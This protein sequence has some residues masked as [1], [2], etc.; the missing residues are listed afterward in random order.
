FRDLTS[1]STPDLINLGPGVLALNTDGDIVYVP[2]ATGGTLGALCTDAPLGN[3]TADNRVGLNDFAV[4]FEDGSIP[5]APDINQVSVGFDCTELPPAKFS[6]DNIGQDIGLHTETSGITVGFLGEAIAI[7]ALATDNTGGTSIGVKT[8]VQGSN[9][10]NVGVISEAFSNTTATATSNFGGRFLATDGTGLNF[11]LFGGA[12]TI[13]SPPA[14]LNVGLGGFANNGNRNTGVS[15]FASGGAIWNHGVQGCA[16]GPPGSETFAGFF[17]GDIS[18][19]GNIY[20]S[21]ENLKENIEP[22]TV[23]SAEF[24]INNLIPV[25]YNHNSSTV[26]GLNL[27]SGHRYGFVAQDVETILPSLVRNVTIP[28]EVDSLGNVISPDQTFKGF[29]YNNLLAILTTNAKAKNLTI[30]SLEEVNATQDSLL[31]DLLNRVEDLE[32]CKCVPKPK[33]QFLGGGDDG[34]DNDD[35]KAQQIDVELKD[36]QNVVLNQNVPNPFAEKTT[37]TYSIPDEVQK[38][39]MLFYDAKGQMINSVDISTRGQGQINVFGEDLSSGIY[40]YTLVTDGGVVL[41]KKMVK[42]K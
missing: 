20:I 33:S 30:D 34:T 24:L 31:A 22:I 1:A 18:V 32:N 6:V 42:A 9:T 21:D 27:S 40:S 13:L 36:V 15:G 12:V 41:T 38:A 7:Q 8:T 23:D 5:T 16:F 19:G 3:L 28:G 25:T 4:F 29:E 26:P 14:S 17:C 39:Q 10:T 11:G 35:S 37:I 2:D